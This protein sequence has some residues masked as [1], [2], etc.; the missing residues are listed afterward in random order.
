MEKWLEDQVNAF[1]KKAQEEG[2]KIIIKDPRPR[3]YLHKKV[4]YKDNSDI[5][6]KLLKQA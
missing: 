3:P 5:F 2:Q 6:M 4:K 1:I